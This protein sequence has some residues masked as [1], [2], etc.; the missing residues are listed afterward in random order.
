[1]LG[2]PRALLMQIAHPAVAAGVAAHSDFPADAFGRLWRTLETMLAI[3]FG[4]SEQCRRAAERVNG[5]HLRIRGSTEHGTPY[6][7]TDPALLKWVHATLV[8]SGLAVYRRFFGRLDQPEADRYV[9]EMN[10]LAVLMGVP[11]ACLWTDAGSFAGYVA[12]TMEGLVVSD[13]ARDLA[14]WIVRP[15]VPP[16]LR[17]VAWFQELVTVGLLPER[18]RAGYGLTWSRSRERLLQASEA[19]ARTA[20]PRLPGTLRRWPQ[21]RAA[22][23]RAAQRPGEGTLGLQGRG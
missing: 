4:D 11:Q 17:P 7:A 5:V 1:M 14:P 13:Q 10:R 16:A 3:S 21:S 8:D 2:G 19:L 23:R 22:E 12:E 18:L 15:P 6:R 9:S 20:V